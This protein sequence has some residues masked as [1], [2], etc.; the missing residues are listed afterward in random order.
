MVIVRKK[1][2]GELYIPIPDE[3]T[4]VYKIEPGDVAVFEIMDDKSFMVRFVRK[5]MFSLVENRRLKK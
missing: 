4:E 2:N 5:D 3:I 1:K